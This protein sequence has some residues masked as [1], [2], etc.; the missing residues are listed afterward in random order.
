MRRRA[1]RPGDLADAQ[2]REVASAL[3]RVRS[4]RTHGVTLMSLEQRLATD[5]GPG[6]AAYVATI[7]AARYAPGSHLPPGASLRGVLRHELASGLG[8]RGWVRSLV[9]IPPGGPSRRGR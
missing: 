6:S 8:L 9:A 2:L 5:V 3:T 7:R 4:W 1:L